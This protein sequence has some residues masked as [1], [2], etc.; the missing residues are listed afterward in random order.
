[1]SPASGDYMWEEDDIEFYSLCFHSIDVP[2]EWGPLNFKPL[3]GN[4]SRGSFRGSEKAIAEMDFT[5]VYQRLKPLPS[6]RPRF[7][8]Q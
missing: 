1:M 6:K 2:S 8:T 3:P 5:P 7:K 4:K